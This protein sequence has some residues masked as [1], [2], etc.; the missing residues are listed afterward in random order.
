MISIE[1]ILLASLI[2]LGAFIIKGLTGF[3]SSL[4]SI[5]FLILFIDL[6]FIVPVMTVVSIFSGLTLFLMT[7]KH[8]VKKEFWIIFIFILLGTLVG[9]KLLVNYS[10][11]FL[12]RI[13]GILIIVFSL[14][15][16]INTQKLLKIKI[17]ESWA[18][19]VGF[20]S[21]ILGGM[22]DTAGPPIVIYFGHKLDK[23]AFRATLVVILFLEAV[24]RTILYSFNGY[25]TFETFKFTFYLLPAVFIGL[26]LGSKIHIKV[27][28]VLFKR[29]ISI[30]LIIAGL[31]LIF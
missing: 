6:K 19:F 22:F 11:I 23:M 12:E 26:F 27:N 9:V 29:I 16:L 8:I 30:I 4:L 21:G 25:I 28:E 5:P 24:W 17:K 2:I 10:T 1:L 15:M 18:V 20:L 3:A 14:N 13:L 31:F 7:K